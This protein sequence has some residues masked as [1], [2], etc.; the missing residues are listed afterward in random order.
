[1]NPPAA[2][3]KRTSGA[4]S[5]AHLVDWREA[6]PAGVVLVTGPEEYLAARAMDRI[7]RQIRESQPDAELTR[8]DASTY[9]AGELTMLASPSLFGEA[10]LIEASALAQMTDDF[11]ADALAYLG[12]AAEDVVLVMHHGGGN[13][14]KKL[15][16]AVKASGAPVIE[17]QPLK[18]DSDKLDFVNQEFRTARR[19][20]DSTAARALVAAVGSQLADLAAACT[21][22]IQDTTG[23]V[24]PDVVERYYG[25]RVEAT[26]FKVADAALAGKGAVALSTL[27]HALSTGVDPVP[28]VAALAMK[29]R[30]V[31]RVA[32]SPKRGADLAKE[33]GLAP[34]QIDQARRDA[35]GWTPDAL[36]TAIKVLAEADAQVKGEA[37][38]PVYAVERAVTT[39]ALSARSGG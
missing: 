11:L 16:D 18:K 22:L 7:R 24:T 31:A 3:G 27:R 8:L 13:R 37:K 30:T 20:L 9:T 29:V 36:V 12:Q 26:A 2:T 32:G 34:W 17:C 28:L 4:K 15:L 39:V 19:R 35:R 10:K 14:G 21:Q 23:D 38:D 6:A 1:V 25:G 33:L 5:A